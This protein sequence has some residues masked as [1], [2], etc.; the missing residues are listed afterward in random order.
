[1]TSVLSCTDVYL[2]TSRANEVSED[3][4][5]LPRRQSHRISVKLWKGVVW[6]SMLNASVWYG[7]VRYGMV[8][9]GMVWYGMVW[10]GMVIIWYWYGDIIN[11][12]GTVW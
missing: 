6:N 8:W 10:Y 7:M 1:M 5:S 3:Q 2:I 11:W 4:F 12:Y 9:Y